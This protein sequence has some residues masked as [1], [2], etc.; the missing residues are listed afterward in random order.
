[1]EGKFPSYPGVCGTVRP[2]RFFPTKT[3]L[4]VYDAV[5]VTVK[6]CEG[7]LCCVTFLPHFALFVCEE[8][9]C[10]VHVCTCM[11]GAAHEES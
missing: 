3:L 10:C 8:S 6:L 9:V 7:I 4:R 5:P 2:L 11:V 1:M